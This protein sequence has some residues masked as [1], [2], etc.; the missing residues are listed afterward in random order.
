MVED[1]D[2]DD[3]GKDSVEF[4]KNLDEL[5]TDR[6]SGDKIQNQGK[7]VRPGTP[8]AKNRN[9]FKHQLNKIKEKNFQ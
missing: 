4:G 8:K 6:K 7:I 9:I 1:K 3:L 5:L 2:K